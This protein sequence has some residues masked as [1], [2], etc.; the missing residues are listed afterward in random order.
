[1]KNLFS[2]QNYCQP[3]KIIL[4]QICSKILLIQVNLSLKEL[5]CG[6]PSLPVSLGYKNEVNTHVKPLH[7]P[8]P[9]EKVKELANQKQQMF[10]DLHKSVR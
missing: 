5:Y 3:L 7:H 2:C 6:L 1:M 10:V 9:W 4:N 8:L